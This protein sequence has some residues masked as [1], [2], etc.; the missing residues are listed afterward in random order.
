MNGYSDELCSICLIPMKESSSHTLECDHVFHTECILKW[1]RSKQES[2]PLCRVHPVVK[3]KVPD[4][5]HRAKSLIEKETNG[6]LCDAFVK[7]KVEELN[8]SERM[9]L[10]HEKDMLNQRESFEKVSIPK[11]EKILREY[12]M[13]RKEFKKKSTPLIKLLDE[14][15]ESDFVERRRIR[16]AINKEKKKKR[17]IMRDIGLHKIET[18]R[19]ISL[20]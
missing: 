12:R 5:I 13:M 9:I 6:T 3:L 10:I 8:E 20:L 4:V 19:R 17:E 2:C 18:I 7:Q 15:D 16:R 1:F 14:I 11:K